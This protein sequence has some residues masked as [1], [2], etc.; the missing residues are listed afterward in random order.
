MKNLKKKVALLLALVMMLTLVPSMNVFG[1]SVGYVEN[2]IVTQL[3]SGVYAVPAPDQ[4]R[5]LS[6]RFPASVFAGLP[7]NVWARIVVESTRTDRIT[8]TGDISNLAGA[9]IAGGLITGSVNPEVGETILRSVTM[10]AVEVDLFRP[11]WATSPAIGSDVRFDIDTNITHRQATINAR[12]EFMFLGADAPFRAATTILSGADVAINQAT[13]LA[14][15]A[16]SVGSVPNIREDRAA[17]EMAPITF[18]ERWPSN[19]TLNSEPV[20]TLTGPAGYRFSGTSADLIGTGG[21]A[22]TNLT[23]SGADFV[24]GTPNVDT[25]R[26]TLTLSLPAVTPRASA[27]MIGG[28]RLEG[29]YIAPTSLTL[30]APVDIS[31]DIT[32]RSGDGTP[33]IDGG[34]SNSYRNFTAVV[35]R[36]NIAGITAT[37]SAPTNIATIVSG[38]NAEW[39]STSILITEA[40]RGSFRGGHVQ[41]EVPHPG[42]VITRARSRTFNYGATPPAWAGSHIRNANQI[43]QN[44]GLFMLP[45]NQVPTGT[46]AERRV[47]EIQLQLRVDPN[48]EGREYE[49][50]V[51]ARVQA[52]GVWTG[53]FVTNFESVVPIA[54]VVDQV[55]V[56]TEDVI[57]VFVGYEGAVFGAAGVAVAQVLPTVT[58]TET[59]AGRLTVGQFV[60]VFLIPRVNGITTPIPWSGQLGFTAP[61]AIITG[62]NGLT[63]SRP[64]TIPIPADGG[65]RP[66]NAIGGV[67]FRVNSASTTAAGSLDFSGL[68]MHGVMWNLPGLS[69]DVAFGGTALGLVP[70]ANAPLGNLPTGAANI[71]NNPLS[72]GNSFIYRYAVTVMELSPTPVADITPPPP[73]PGPGPG[74]GP[75]TGYVNGTFVIAAADTIGGVARPFVVVGGDTFIA[76]RSLTHVLNPNMLNPDDYIAWANPVA[77]FRMVNVYGDMV[78][79]VMTNNSNVAYVDGVAITLNNGPRLIDGRTMVPLTEIGNILGYAITTTGGGLAQQ[80]IITW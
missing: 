12:I 33:I 37:S 4:A 47:I 71:T 5:T 17:V 45:E 60:D 13:A 77:T 42:V 64:T 7:D 58:L 6:I 57:E 67:R 14:G 74:P 66:A 59:A 68:V 48:F 54:N 44:G 69:F 18:T 53:G 56:E 39:N 3:A 19:F 21:L 22:G 26:Q 16:V 75:E 79:I 10:A 52:F 38:T 63:L 43:V 55:S 49:T 1:A 62:T 11:G 36:Q 23:V 32:V 70:W 34:P 35:A 28:F 80:V 73:A 40:G 24:I 61:D 20:I 65:E 29:V 46:D 27:T 41:V 72:Q 30:L 2:P 76:L 25:D 8:L 31:V 50:A 78:E 51:S 9:N 15:F